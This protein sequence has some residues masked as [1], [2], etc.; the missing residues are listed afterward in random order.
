M[1]AFRRGDRGGDWWI[2]FRYRG[3]RIRKRA[4][5]QTKRAAETFERTLR[6]ELVAD[7]EAGRD[8]FAGP[9]PTFAEFATEWFDRYV[10]VQNRICAQS[11]KR[12]ALDRHLI[13]EFGRLR[14]NAISTELIDRFASRKLDANLRPKTI[15]NLLT[16]L[17]CSLV[18]AQE[19]GKLA[20]VPRVRWLKVPEQPYECLTPDEVERVVAASGP[21]F[22]QA[23]ITFIADT[24][25]RFGEAAALAWADV[26]LDGPEPQARICRGASLGTIGPT[27]NGRVRVVPLTQRV[28]ARLRALPRDCSLVFPRS[29]LDDTRA[30]LASH[31]VYGLHRACA[32]AGVRNVGW[33]ALRHSLATTLCQ[34]GVPLRDVQAL[35]GHSTI[36]M[37]SRYAHATPADVR[38]WMNRCWNPAEGTNGHLLATDAETSPRPT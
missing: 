29:D 7:E 11:E 26:V 4:P 16:I 22:W 33:H 18:V 24:G 25:V 36:L 31:T 9:P 1:A 15:N 32:R 20:R 14:L 2:D 3:R 10:R 35:L 21:G 28:C 13:P 38:Y 8:P 5:V 34:R 27:K 30:L 23:L 37:T 19:W 17:R 6:N 12:I